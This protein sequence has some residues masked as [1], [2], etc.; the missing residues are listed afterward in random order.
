MHGT[1]LLLT[2]RDLIGA[3]ISDIRIKMHLKRYPTYDWGPRSASY[4]NR[5]LKEDLDKYD[6]L[7]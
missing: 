2:L 5:E 1:Y 4:I 7:R 3:C 6:N